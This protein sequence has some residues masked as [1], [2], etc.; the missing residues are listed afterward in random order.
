MSE[1]H[2][3]NDPW[4]LISAHQYEKAIAAPYSRLAKITTP[5]SPI[6]QSH[7][8][9][10][11]V[12]LKRWRVLQRQMTS[13]VGT[14]VH[15]NRPGPL[16]QFVLERQSFNEV[17]RDP[18]KPDNLLEAAERAKSDILKRRELVQAL[19]VFATKCQQRRDKNGCRRALQQSG[20]DTAGVRPAPR[21]EL[22]R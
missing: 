4:H 2:Q 20:G 17:L 18:F 14:G 15:P 22:G 5:S 10:S 6:V 21:A 7:S 13:L 9:A 12:Y 11:A 19:F 1:D 16:T 3:S 8:S